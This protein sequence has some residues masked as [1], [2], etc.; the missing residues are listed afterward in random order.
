VE[1]DHLRA[2]TLGGF[3]LRQ[4]GRD[5]QRHANSRR[6]ELAHPGRDAFHIRRHLEA[7]LGGDLGAILGNE[8][9]VMRPDADGDLQHFVG[10]PHLE[11][12]ARLQQRT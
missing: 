4:I 3:D 9:A 7:A 6:A 12:H 5:E 1:L 11:I 8:A 2:R 10:Q